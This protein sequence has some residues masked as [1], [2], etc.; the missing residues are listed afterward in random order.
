MIQI[1]ECY[2]KFSESMLP[3]RQRLS[4]SEGQPVKLKMLCP[5]KIIC[6]RQNLPSFVVSTQ[7]RH[8]FGI[9]PLI[10]T[11]VYTYHY[12]IFKNILFLEINSIHETSSSQFLLSLKNILSCT[13]RYFSIKKVLF[14]P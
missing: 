7:Y 1:A 9:L 6:W 5:F 10:L 2:D 12:T 14:Y 8:T 13:S 3:E 4:S 11:P